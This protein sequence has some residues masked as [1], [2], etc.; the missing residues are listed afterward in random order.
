MWKRKL[1]TEKERDEIDQKAGPIRHAIRDD[2][3]VDLKVRKLNSDFTCPVCLGILRET[4]TVMECLHRFC[5]VCIELSLRMGKKECPSCRTKCPS[6]RH[7]RRDHAFDKIIRSVYPDIS[8]EDAQQEEEIDQILSQYNV[9]AFTQAI[10]RGN[11]VQSAVRRKT[12]LPRAFSQRY[13]DRQK[14][15]PKIQLEIEEPRFTFGLTLHPKCPNTSSHHKLDLPRNYMRCP[16]SVT[17]ECLRRYLKQNVIVKD[18]RFELDFEIT[19]D[20]DPESSLAP[21]SKRLYACAR[22]MAALEGKERLVVFYYRP[23]WTQVSESE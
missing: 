12:R 18:N 9:D 17:V 14:R 20:L 19:C 21:E 5:A 6:K 4:T 3:T 16:K 13:H 11:N 22:E 2:R 23:V 8:Q 7:L 1:E 10:E 15:K